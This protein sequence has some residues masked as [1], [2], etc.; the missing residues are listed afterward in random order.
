MQSERKRTRRRVLLF[1][2]ALVFALVL[3]FSLLSLPP[4]DPVV[5]RAAAGAPAPSVLD[6]FDDVTQWTAEASHGARLEIAQDAG[7]SGMALRLDFDLGETGGFVIARK[8]VRAHLPAN[9]AFTFQMRGEGPP[10]TLEFKLVDRSGNNVWRYRR[11][12]FTPPAEWTLTTLR[13]RRIEFAWGPAGGGDI[14]DLGSIEL[15]V[16]STPGAKGSLWIDDLRL[17][18]REPVARDG[19][20]PVAR[21]S[22]SAPGHEPEQ[23]LDADPA[24]AWRSGALGASQWLLLDLGA[25]REYGG[26]V[27]EWEL[28]DYATAYEVLTSDDGT[29][30]TAAYRNVAGNGGRDYVYLPDGESRYLRLDLEQSSRGQGYGIRDVSLQPFEFSASPNQFFETLAREAAPGMFPKY[31]SGIQSYWTVVGVDRDDKEALVNEEGMI[32]VDEGAFSIEPFLYADGQLISWKSVRTSQTLADGQL[33]IPIVS[34]EHDT[35]GLRATAFAA[36]REGASILYADYA[37]ENRADTPREIVLFLALRPFQVLPPW[38]NLNRVGGVASI[39]KIEFFQESRAGQP[40]VL[41][42]R[43]GQPRVPEPRADEPGTPGP[44]AGNFPEHTVLV[45]GTKVVR[46]L[47]P[48]DAFGAAALEEADITEFLSRGTVPPRT[49]IT[50][51]VGYASGALQYRLNLAPRAEAHVYVAVPF[52]DPHDADTIAAGD[53]AALDVDTARRRTVEG[54]QRLFDRVG[55]EVPPEAEAVIRTAR[56]TLAYILINRDGDAI[57]PGSRTYARSW[58]RDGAVTAGALLDVGFPQEV[59]DFIRWFARYQQPNGKVPCCVDWRGADPVPEH[60]SGGEFVYTI[61]EY[62][63]HTRDVGLVHDLWPNVVRAVEYLDSLRQ[64]RLGDEYRRPDK[65]PYFG[66]L[67][68]S[69]SHEGYSARPVHSYWDDFWALRGLKDAVFLAGVVGDD[70][71]ATSFAALRD[72]FRRDLYASIARTMADHGIDYVP[73]SVELGDFD[74]SSTAIA[75]SPGGELE[76]LPQPALKRTFDRYFDGV[77]QRRQDVG[78]PGSAYTPYELRN[79]DALVRMNERARAVEL[80]WSFV[81]DQRPRGWNQWPE[82]LWQDPST[83]KFIGDMP[84]TWVASSYIRAVRDLFVYERESDDALVVA[85]GLSRAVVMSDAGVTVR[86]LSTHYGVLN[87]AIHT[88]AVPRQA[89]PAQT[90]PSETS[91]GQASQADSAQGPPALEFR[92]GGDLSVPSG[93][94]VIQ[95]PAD[96]P[97]RAVTVNGHAIDTF[98]ADTATIREFPAEVVLQ[99]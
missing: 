63:R 73:A 98:T 25:R 54:W 85:A 50:D 15:A 43:A 5:R 30:W 41:E 95:P 42:P 96:A 71:R 78:D 97:I 74:P 56:T 27:I 33:P 77:V 76:N 20:P 39:G 1:A 7:P 62:Y 8:A 21:A 34:W 17:E 10:I 6:S 91:R 22:T 61:A 90:S 87:L 65:L 3:V 2:V 57:Q 35:V 51:S 55:V 45:N 16:A 81:N 67:P 32:E 49:Q 58:I 72:D 46:A 31:F 64:Q 13:K 47:T 48:P 36:E 60:D 11:A 29:T 75:I 53:R 99:Y 37:V 23:A 94:I 28:E 4:L 59:H 84:H 79:V 66:L 80:L 12:A 93:G 18:P 68:E 40:R 24:S 44:H 92:L 19:G 83:P 88:Q 82:L 14:R 86:R 52:H 89:M 70:A 38:Q 9:Y 26:L 69:I